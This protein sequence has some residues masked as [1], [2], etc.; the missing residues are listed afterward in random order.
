MNSIITFP[1]THGYSSSFDSRYD[2]KRCWPECHPEGFEKE[3]QV[4]KLQI[5]RSPLEELKKW[6]VWIAV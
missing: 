2:L 5:T 4:S 3:G 6:N 1:M